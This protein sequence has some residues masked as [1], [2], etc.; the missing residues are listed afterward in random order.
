[1]LLVRGLELPDSNVISLVP[2]S[3]DPEESLD[4]I[5]IVVEPAAYTH[6]AEHLLRRTIWTY[7]S[8]LR[9]NPFC[10]SSLGTLYKTLELDYYRKLAKGKPG[11]GIICQEKSN[12]IS[13]ALV[14]EGRIVA[15]ANSYDCDHFHVYSAVQP[16][17]INDKLVEL[18]NERLVIPTDFF[19]TVR[20]YSL[21]GHDISIERRKVSSISEANL[22][23][24]IEN[25]LRYE[26]LR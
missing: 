25:S 11:I 4:T 21:E 14:R 8:S 26:G 2:V 17:S 5:E 9:K 24:E 6:V 13:A 12:S 3:F 10:I 15:L 22:G 1:M 16:E 19:G 18:V 20:G 23:L 7:N